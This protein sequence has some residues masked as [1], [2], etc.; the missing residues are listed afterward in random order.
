LASRHKGGLLPFLLLPFLHAALDI[1]WLASVSI[2]R[3]GRSGLAVLEGVAP[4]RN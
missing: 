4:G 2:D 1:V 3:Y